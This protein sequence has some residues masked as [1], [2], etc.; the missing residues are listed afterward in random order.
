MNKTAKLTSVFEGF[1][2]NLKQQSLVGYLDKEGMLKQDKIF[3]QLKKKLASH[4]FDIDGKIAGAHSLFHIR[5]KGDTIA[6]LA[7][8]H[9]CAG[10]VSVR[11]YTLMNT[12]L[13]P[14]VSDIFVDKYFFN[15]S[16]DVMKEIC[17]KNNR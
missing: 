16:L 5:F 10:R 3:K 8:F 12:N 1:F 11:A 6:F 14:V 17:E 9:G 2:K 4:R 13:Q 15:D 7:V